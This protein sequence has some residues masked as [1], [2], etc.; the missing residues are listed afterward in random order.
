MCTLWPLSRSLARPP[1]EN[2]GGRRTVATWTPG[3]SVLFIWT[4]NAISTATHR[5]RQPTAQHQH[6][7]NLLSFGPSFPCPSWALYQQIIIYK[8][9]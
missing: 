6:L 1:D 7:C 3:L 5:I 8:H 4:R 2:C 9:N